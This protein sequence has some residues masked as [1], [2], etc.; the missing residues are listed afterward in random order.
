MPC[1]ESLYFGRNELAHANYADA[2]TF[3][4][5]GASPQHFGRVVS[6]TPTRL[7]LAEPVKWN[8]K[9]FKDG[10]RDHLLFVL[11]GK[12]RGQFRRVVEA[13]GNT[14][15]VEPPLEVVPDA[16]SVVGVNHNVSD[17]VVVGNRFADSTCVQIYGIGF[18]ILFAENLL[19][20]L[21]NGLAL[22]GTVHGREVP[23]PN[24]F[25]QALAN[26]LTSPRFDPRV[27]ARRIIESG[28]GLWN[29]Y[30]RGEKFPH[31]F[32]VGCVVRGNEIHGGMI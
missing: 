26:R 20:R 7:T 29:F 2:E 17:W 11:D 32:T 3:S 27:Y 28:V 23:E 30:P 16:T 19:E 15:T 5:D 6:A 31:P 24:F 12:G 21:S 4:T 25:I 8:T 13:S 10:P 9:R 14:V 1:V 22:W 18:N